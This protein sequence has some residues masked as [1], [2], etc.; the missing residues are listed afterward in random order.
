MVQFAYTFFSMNIRLLFWFLL[1]LTSSTWSLFAWN[2]PTKGNYYIDL[3]Q[4]DPL[5]HTSE[6]S[7]PWGR[8]ALMTIL[9]SFSEILLFTIPLIAVVSLII[10]G[11]L[12]IF[13]SW[14]TEKTNRGKTIIKWNI[15]AILVAFLSWT[16]VQIIATLFT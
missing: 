2:D 3:N 5:T 15:V 10:A 12:Y 4:M 11:Y 7:I 16:L 1:A 13:S 8:A 14:D 6:W 9:Q